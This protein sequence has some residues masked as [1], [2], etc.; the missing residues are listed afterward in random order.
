MLRKAATNRDQPIALVTLW[1]DISLESAVDDL[2]QIQK[3]A[4]EIIQERFGIKVE[5]V[6]QSIEAAL[7]TDEQA[8]K[9]G[10]QP[11]EAALIVRRDYATAPDT[12]PFLIA[13]SVCKA[14]TF[15]VF[16]RFRCGT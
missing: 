16:S 12:D 9:L 13:K 1:L 6:E 15:K 10:A 3:S 8:E 14:D 11:G 4:A 2:S 7:L 5:S